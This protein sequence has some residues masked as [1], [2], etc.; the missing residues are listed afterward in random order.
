[1][2]APEPITLVEILSV[3]GDFDSCAELARAAVARLERVG[4]RSLRSVNFFTRPD[5]NEIGAVLEFADGR[6][7]IA[8][9][10]QI[11]GW[12]EFKRLAERIKLKEMRV[13]GRIPLEAEAWMRQ[14]GDDITHYGSFV[15]GFH[16]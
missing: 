6:E 7:L 11:S 4:V 8:H 3:H 5:S 2:S 13:H 16:R 14:F 15:A 12:D 9:M 1:M 10:N